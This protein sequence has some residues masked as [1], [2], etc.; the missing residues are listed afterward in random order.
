MDPGTITA[1]RTAEATLTNL[2]YAQSHPT[3]KGS[4]RE[5]TGAEHEIPGY[6]SW[7]RAQVQ[8]GNLPAVTPPENYAFTNQVE[9]LHLKATP[10]Y[11]APTVTN[12]AQAVTHR[13]EL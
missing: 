8:L 13:P 1:I 2:A 6:I 12:G 7:L 4:I 5:F 10:S 3:F 9:G 11:R